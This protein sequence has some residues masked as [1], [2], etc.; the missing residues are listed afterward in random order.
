MAAFVIADVNVKDPEKFREY[1]K[2][3][4]DILK[5]YGGR[6]LVRGGDVEVSEGSWVPNRLV[7]M[8]FESIIELKRWYN[9]P[10][11]TQALKIRQQSADSNVVIVEG[12]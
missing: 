1:S 11:Y 12:I 2:L 9:S 4:P 5:T 8:E 6:Y 7:V 3:T 10:D